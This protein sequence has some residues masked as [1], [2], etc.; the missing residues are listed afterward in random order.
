MLGNFKK[1]A[2]FLTNQE[3]QMFGNDR[4]L[5]TICNTEHKVIVEITEQ[6][7][8]QRCI[9]KTVKYLRW[10]VLQKGRGEGF[11]NQDT[12][13]NILSKTLEQEAQH[14]NILE[15]FLLDSHVKLHFEWEIQNIVTIRAFLS[16]IRGFFWIFKNGR[17]ASP[18]L[19]C[20][21]SVCVAEYGYP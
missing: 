17:E 21:A 4:W 3:T 15:F 10:S 8:R 11:W 16:K 20:W 19:P 2:S 18:C 5:V 6:L 14:G 1:S 12:S 13:I 7:L 9:Q